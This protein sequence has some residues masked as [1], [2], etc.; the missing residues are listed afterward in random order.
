VETQHSKG[1]LR[2][3]SENYQQVLVPEHQGAIGDLIPLE[4]SGLEDGI[5]CHHPQTKRVNS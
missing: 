5:L 4:I 2:G 1:W 3:T